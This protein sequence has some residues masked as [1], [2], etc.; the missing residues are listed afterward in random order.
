[1]DARRKWEIE[2][3]IIAHHE[4]GHAVVAEELGWSVYWVGV[5]FDEQ[6]PEIH[7]YTSVPRL[8]ETEPDHWAVMLAGPAAEQYYRAATQKG[9][10][11]T[12]SVRE[13]RQQVSDA[14]TATCYR[15]FADW[16]DEAVQQVWDRIARLAEKIQT[17]PSRSVW[18][19]DFREASSKKFAALPQ[20]D[21]RA[22]HE[23]EDPLTP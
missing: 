12:L 1:V 13:E 11:L 10:G 7:G 19:A 2:L 4:A 9:K 6:L 15:E 18:G 21:V 3:P 22:E 17:A 20:L 14:L 5:H 16:A 8:D 23:H